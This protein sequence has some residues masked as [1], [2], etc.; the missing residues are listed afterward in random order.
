MR[1]IVFLFYV[2]ALWACSTK[3]NQ[4]A[5]LRAITPNK[6]DLICS[7]DVIPSRLIQTIPVALLQELESIGIA[8]C[9]NT[10]DFFQFAASGLALDQNMNISALLNE[11]VLWLKASIKD[12][13]K[14]VA[15]LMT[16]KN[17]DIKKES[18]GSSTE[19]LFP[20]YKSLIVW[21]KQT[22]CFLFSD[23][24][25]QDLSGLFKQLLHSSI[26]KESNLPLNND[27]LM[28][29]F[30]N[31]QS[32]K[33][34]KD[35]TSA[36]Y[37]D[38]NI[39]NNQDSI[40]LHAELNNFDH[41][42]HSAN[43]G[44]HLGDTNS[45]FQSN[46]D[47]AAFKPAIDYYLSRAFTKSNEVNL[48]K[49][50]LS[51][52]LSICYRGIKNN[53]TTIITYE[54]DENFEPVE[55]KKTQ[56]NYYPDITLKIGIKDSELADS[57]LTLL[58]HKNII[59]KNGE[60][61][62]PILNKIPLLIKKD[63]LKIYC[64]TNNEPDKNKT[65][66]PED[67]QTELISVYSNKKDLKELNRSLFKDNNLDTLLSKIIIVDDFRLNLS[68]QGTLT[69]SLKNTATEKNTMYNL[70]RSY[71]ET[72]RFLSKQNRT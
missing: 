52:A 25:N 56:N 66:K 61:F 43:P 10:S 46:I 54:Y 4:Y 51:G 3:K 64:S 21:D 30:V 57:L 27:L 37:I 63:S 60:G 13:E 24:L 16:E 55:I 70:I 34:P 7:F 5:P 29:G 22:A 42:L 67:S 35:T 59:K 1:N 32:L 17:A 68:Q 47:V 39:Y 14:W 26:V 2:L 69:F 9:Y 6:N 50:A 38:F 20:C 31:T 8:N 72:K 28:S 19:L 71:L 48:L 53:S 41:F 36:S 12:S 11:R 49:T 62:E 33:S 40:C 15:F 58:V 45:H 18:Y 65:P 44:F 23:N